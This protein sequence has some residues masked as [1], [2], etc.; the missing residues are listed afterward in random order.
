[1]WKPKSWLPSHS[2]P[3]KGLL[4]EDEQT[5]VFLGG[6]LLITV[7]CNRKVCYVGIRKIKREREERNLHH[8][9]PEVSGCQLLKITS[10][11]PPARFGCFM[12]K[13]AKPKRRE[14][15]A[16]VTHGLTGGARIPNTLPLSV[17]HYCHRKSTPFNTH[18]RPITS[19][20]AIH[21][22]S[23]LLKTAI[24]DPSMRSNKMCILNTRTTPDDEPARG[25]CIPP[26]PPWG[27]AQ[28]V[29]ISAGAHKAETHHT[30]CRR[31]KLLQLC[32]PLC[33]PMGRSPP[34][35]S[36]PGILQAG[37]LEQVAMPSSRE[38]S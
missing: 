1:M 22:S 16:E 34:G 29:N 36:V 7:F 15:L 25:T 35:S 19:T 11:L 13:Q 6:L 10:Y 9:R 32:L 3:N 2:I 26:R 12:D 18:L 33:G 24:G 37:I 14:G 23:H 27:R 4:N 17:H 31:A 21:A 5:L 20:A 38:S 30:R 28:P 8:W